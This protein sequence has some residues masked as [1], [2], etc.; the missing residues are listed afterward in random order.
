MAAFL[1]VQV[2]AEDQIRLKPGSELYLT[3]KAQQVSK[4]SFTVKGQP[5]STRPSLGGVEV[6]A[7]VFTHDDVMTCN[8]MSFSV[9]YFLENGDRRACLKF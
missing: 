6:A 7:E 4:S 3:L 9:L 1:S 8:S 2:P 5:F